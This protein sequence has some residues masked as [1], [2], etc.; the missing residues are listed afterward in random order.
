LISIWLRTTAAGDGAAGSGCDAAPYFRVFN[1]AL[2]I[3]KF[4]PEL[5]Y[6]KT[7]VP[8]FGTEKYP[9]PMVDH[10]TARKRVLEVYKE[11]WDES[12]ACC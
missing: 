12:M 9:E 11:R 6:I 8:E 10:T 1:P 4:D 5:L 2:Q 7:W 3:E